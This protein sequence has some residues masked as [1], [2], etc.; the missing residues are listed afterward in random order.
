MRSEGREWR[1]DEEPEEVSEEGLKQ[2]EKIS[3]LYIGF[4]GKWEIVVRVIEK[5][6]REFTNKSGKLT[7]IFSM[8]MV[9]RTGMK[10]DGVMFGDSAKEHHD[11]IKLH[12]I[13]RISRGQI[14]EENYN[15]T[16]RKDYSKYNIIFSKESVFVPVCELASIPRASTSDPTLQQIIAEN[17]FERTYN[18]AA[19]LLEIGEERNI[20]K[21]DRTIFKKSLVVGDPETKK[22]ID[23]VV[24]NKDLYINPMWLDKTILLKSFKLHNYRDT[25]SFSSIFRSEIVPAEEHRFSRLEGKLAKEDYEPTSEH[26]E[27]NKAQDSRFSRFVK[28][29]EA[30][31][32]YSNSLEPVY[33]DLEVW[34]THMSFKNKWFYDACNNPKCKKAAESG[35]KCL[36]CGHFNE[37][38]QRRF[39]IPIEL[40]DCTGSIWTTAFDELSHEI[41]RGTN[42]Q[43]LSRM[44]ESRLKEEAECRLYQQFRLRVSSRKEVEGNVKHSIVGKVA[45]VSL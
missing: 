3:D 31:V 10:I 30:E 29:I 5:S 24:W 28:E 16:K 6:Y 37:I 21:G 4:Q 11:L 41:F 12:H 8:T 20:E 40:S 32:M 19:I 2:Y 35:Q 18:F 15:Q 13:Y 9:D 7:K 33:S 39:I 1:G 26:R 23:V 42:I 45:E 25:L 27:D 43:E 14:R 36:N 38:V 17:D 34:I 44:E 22:S